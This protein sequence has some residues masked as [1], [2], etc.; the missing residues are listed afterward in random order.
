MLFFSEQV[1]RQLINYYCLLIILMLKEVLNKS[2]LEFKNEIEIK[3]INFRYD[4]NS[5]SGF[6]IKNFN[7]KIKK[8]DIVAFVGPSGSGKTTIINILMGLLKPQSGQ[9]LV[10]KKI[11]D[12][13]TLENWVKKYHMLQ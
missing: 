2:N 11:L 3:N 4:L 8:G 13:S 5:N 7:L 1:N 10:D 9:I 12:Y 6:N